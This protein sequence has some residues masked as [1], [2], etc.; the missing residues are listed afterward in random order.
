MKKRFIDKFWGFAMLSIVLGLVCCE[1]EPGND[2]TTDRLFAPP[3]FTVSPGSTTAHMTWIPI[4]NATY[5]LEVSRDTLQFEVELQTFD[6]EDVDVFD[7]SGLWGRSLYSA[8]IKSISHEPDV[9]DSRF[10]Q[11]TFTT[12]QENIFITPKAEDI[13][14]T[15]ILISWQG[16]A[17]VTK[18]TVN[19][20][21]FWR[22]YM[23]TEEDLAAKKILVEEL[24][25]DVSYRFNIYSDDHMRDYIYV[26]TAPEP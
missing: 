26:S 15:S 23:L 1:D 25:P 4:R 11:L 17:G 13:T 2:Q 6:L 19:T 5:R 21:G 16:G 20:T 14:P 10:N 7:L 18:I 22:K 3:R 8:R 9:A 12:S 24:E